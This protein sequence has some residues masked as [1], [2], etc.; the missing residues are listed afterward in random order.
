MNIFSDPLKSFDRLF[1][2]ISDTLNEGV[3][4]LFDKEIKIGVTGFSRGGKTAFITSLVNTILNF[5]NEGISDR[6]PRFSEYEKAGIY[7]GGI[8][9]NHD[10]S[11]PAFPYHEYYDCLVK[12]NPQWPVATDNISEI[13][14]EIRFKENRLLMP[15]NNRNLYLDIWDYPGEWLI[16]LVLL[17]LSYEDFSRM[18]LAQ[19]NKLSKL[20]SCTEPLLALGERLSPLKTPDPRQL[21]DSV[22][23]YVK[24]LLECKKAGMSLIVPSRQVLPGNLA[25]APIIE[26]MPWLWEIPEDYPKNSL[27][28]VM[29]KRYESYKKDI[30]QNFYETIFSKLDRQVIL[31][32]C[33]SALGGGREA[34]VN[35]NDT[36]EILLKNFSYG[37]NNLLQ[38]IFSPKIDKVIFAAT[39]A[40]QITYDE[41]KHLLSLLR[42]MVTSASHE[43]RGQSSNCQYMVLSS[44]AATKCLEVNYQGKNTQ[45]LS[46]GREE[47]KYF[48]PGSIPSQWSEQSMEDFKQHFILRELQPPVISPGDPIP[49]INMD[50]M[51]SYLLKDKL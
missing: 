4:R 30:V 25:G 27:Y 12:D 48:Y 1:D 39:K 3:N 49:N 29:K 15:G 14:L 7:Y 37:E 36:F 8:A 26:F 19:V 24:W 21:K 45:V 40:D 28:A 38:R 43:I 17:N 41:E 23:L 35:V 31:I 16:D 11:V 44:I 47:D 42:S 6:L 2:E 13:R 33:F 18:M 46:T 20:I 50:V 22:A 51:L 34:F 5:G 10:L 9:P 32:D